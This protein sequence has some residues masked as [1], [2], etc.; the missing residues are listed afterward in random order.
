[1]SHSRCYFASVVHKGCIYAI[2][3]DPGGHAYGDSLTSVESLSGK[4]KKWKKKAA[5]PQPRVFHSAVVF[6]D[7]I[8]VCG[9]Q[10]DLLD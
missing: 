9:G 1:M 2:G 5:L 10:V 7:E 6:K 4:S 8:W 3:G